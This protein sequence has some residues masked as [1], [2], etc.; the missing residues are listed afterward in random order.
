MYV[1]FIHDYF[2]D[3]L[4]LSL[5]WTVCRYVSGK[6]SLLVCLFFFPP[7]YFSP[8]NSCSLC[9]RQRLL[10]RFLHPSLNTL[11]LL[12]AKIDSISQTSFDVVSRLNCLISVSSFSLHSVEV[13]LSLLILVFLLRAVSLHCEIDLQTSCISES[14]RSPAV[15]WPPCRRSRHSMCTYLSIDCHSSVR[16]N[17]HCIQTPP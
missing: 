16:Q 1:S 17:S 2:N 13:F 8:E 3:R 10:L 4:L 15:S 11:R 5:P 14:W 6:V 7:E 12:S 9:G